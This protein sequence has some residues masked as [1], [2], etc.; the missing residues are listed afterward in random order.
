VAYLKALLRHLPWDT[1]HI[2]KGLATFQVLKATSIKAAVFWDVAPCSVVDTSR[3]FRGTYCLHHEGYGQY[4]SDNTEQHNN[5]QPSSL[6]T[7]VRTAGIMIEI[8]T[9]YQEVV[10][11]LLPWMGWTLD[12]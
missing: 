12:V 11:M 9:G 2:T 3:R 1:A 6:K 5:R 10:E 7:Q 8:R 4:P